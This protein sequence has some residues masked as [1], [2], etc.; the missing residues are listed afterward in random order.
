MKVKTLVC[1]GRN[2]QPLHSDEMNAGELV[3]E[4][5]LDGCYAQ[6]QFSIEIG[7]EILQEVL[8][9]AED[10]S[11][12]YVLMRNAMEQSPSKVI[13]NLMPKA[14]GESSSDGSSRIV[15]PSHLKDD[16]MLARISKRLAELTAL[17]LHN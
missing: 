11:D 12:T 6:L 14:G 3:F 5:E 2:L 9:A 16:G 4:S 1:N 15:V 17:R 13:H 10:D 8:R 7:S